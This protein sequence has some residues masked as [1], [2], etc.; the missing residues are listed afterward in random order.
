MPKALYSHKTYG[1]QM[2]SRLALQTS[3]P[4]EG[5]LTSCSS[6]WDEAL[7][8]HA[9]APASCPKELQRSFAHQKTSER[10][11]ALSQSES[12]PI[13]APEV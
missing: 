5:S 7:P 12:V 9:S 2:L 8:T 13:R 11:A 6:V 3:A 1:T 10:T 4:V